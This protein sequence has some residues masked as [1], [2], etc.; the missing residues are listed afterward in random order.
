VVKDGIA[1]LQAGVSQAMPCL[2]FVAELT[3]GQGGIVFDSDPYD[4]W[5][6]T[7]NKLGA[8]LNTFIASACTTRLTAFLQV[9]TRCA[10]PQLRRSIWPSRR[11]ARATEAEKAMQRRWRAM[12]SHVFRSWLGRVPPQ[13]AAVWC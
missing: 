12:Q 6:E 10:S 5:M 3:I 2:A 13:G 8:L 1:Y 4:E 7:I 11:T 9:Q